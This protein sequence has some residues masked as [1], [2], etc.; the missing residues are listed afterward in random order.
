MSVDDLVQW[1]R[2]FPRTV[3]DGCVA[4]RDLLLWG[5]VYPRVLDMK[6][7]AAMRADWPGYRA[8]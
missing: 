2:S 5:Q 1:L 4:L 6:T 3:S 7:L 8:E